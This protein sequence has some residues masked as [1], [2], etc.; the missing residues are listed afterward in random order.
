LKEKE[1]EAIKANQAEVKENQLKQ[2]GADFRP[3]QR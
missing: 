3:Y 1:L 2:H